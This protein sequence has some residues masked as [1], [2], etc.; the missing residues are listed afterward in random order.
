M[1]AHRYTSLAAGVAAVSLVLAGCGQ[2][3][4]GSASGGDGGDGG[5]GGGGNDTPTVAFVP[6]LQGIP[7]FEAMNT[8]GQQACEELGCEWLYQG[9]VEADAAGQ[10]DI[11]RSFIQQGVDVL[12]V[13]PNDPDSMAP[14]LQQ[15]ADAGIAVGTTDTDA[16]NSVRQVF[17]QQASDE[18]IG[19]TLTDQLMEAMGG[20][21]RYAI[22]SCGETA[23]NLNSWIEVQR[24]Y[25]ASEYPEAEITE[26]VYAGEDQSVATQMATDLMN[27][28]P[29]LTGLV[30][31][32]T[33][34][35]PG[36]AQAVRD[37]GRIGQVFTVGL[38][39]PNS[40]APYLADGSSSASVL[41]DVENLGYLTAWAG[42]Q[43]A[44]G[45]EFSA[46]PEVGGDISGV[47]YDDGSKVLLLG[48]PLVLTTENVDEFDY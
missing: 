19:Q 42:M 20:S 30:G 44:A 16:P 6:K 40:M 24:E 39:T 11:V 38:G 4:G 29:T 41:W 47:S 34:S 27:S 46:S 28:D 21:G 13:A 26:V 33:S 37:A 12:F 5:G 8:G 36:V 2:G 14:L 17:V 18:G 10:A 45:E 15:A 32:C 31:E 1:R 7:Y 23:E 3:S 9:P 25:T 48:D 22:V 43:L 35:A